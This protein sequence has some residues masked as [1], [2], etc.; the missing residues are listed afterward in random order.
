M[1]AEINYSIPTEVQYCNAQNEMYPVHV[2][3]EKNIAKF[4]HV[5]FF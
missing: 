5:L 4:I 3:K 2:K 1:P